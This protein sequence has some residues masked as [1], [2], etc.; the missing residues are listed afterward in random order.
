MRTQAQLPRLAGIG[1]PLF[2]EQCE[3]L[4]AAIELLDL[5][6]LHSLA[7][8]VFISRFCV[9]RDAIERLFRHEEALLSQYRLPAETRRLHGDDQRRI[10]RI[11]D[12]IH[13]DAMNRKNR[14]A[15]EVYETLRFEIERHVSDFGD[16]L[17]RHIPV[18]KH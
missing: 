7:S 8:E 4:A 17:S 6:P 12:D 11:L 9:L 14:T 13:A 3:D 18:A 2:D 5:N 16:D 10:R 15:I 1:L